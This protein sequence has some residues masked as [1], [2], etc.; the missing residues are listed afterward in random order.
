[1]RNKGILVILISFVVAFVGNAYAAQPTLVYVN[2]NLIE[3]DVPAQIIDGRLM[4]PVRFIAEELG[5]EV[6]YDGSSN[7]VM[8]STKKPMDNYLLKLDNELTTWPYW[9]EDG[10]L[11]L[12]RRNCIEM[13]RTTYK[14]QWHSVNIFP[15]GTVSIDHKNIKVETRQIDGFT[16]ICV[17]DLKRL[18]I[19]DYDWDPQTGHL[20]LKPQ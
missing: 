4:V 6:Q 9:S 16:T 10:K 3:S 12:E 5:A 15:D 18:K 14:P 11:F 17:N 1:M 2:D 20:V 13:L 7:K 19:I 8:I